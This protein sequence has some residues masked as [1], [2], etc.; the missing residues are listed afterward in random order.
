MAMLFRMTPWFLAAAAIGSVRVLSGWM[1][2]LRRSSAAR[3]DIAA[4]AI[5]LFAVVP[6][7][8]SCPKRRT[9]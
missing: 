9:G 3:P 1:M 8:M 6:Y 5:L 7:A 2:D 4:A